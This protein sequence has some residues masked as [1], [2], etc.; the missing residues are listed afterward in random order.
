MAEIDYTLL[1]YLEKL[2]KK[3]KEGKASIIGLETESKFSTIS[4]DNI[5]LQ[6]VPKGYSINKI[7]YYEDDDE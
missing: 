4:L 5:T 3:T 2:I 6:Y 7:I 1:H